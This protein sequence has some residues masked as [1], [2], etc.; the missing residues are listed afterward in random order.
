MIAL[1]LSLFLLLIQ[2]SVV[3]PLGT[4]GCDT[5]GVGVAYIRLD[6][7]GSI[8]EGPVIAHERKHLEQI[9]RFA[10][11]GEWQRWYSE[12]TVEAEA[13]AFCAAAKAA[14]KPDFTLGGAVGK[15]AHSMAAAFG[16]SFGQALLLIDAHC[17]GEQRS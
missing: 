10:S 17:V 2:Q 9:K 1:L 8:E 13:E 11:C 3:A 14:V 15:Y 5:H 4:T 16:I 12:N 7:L 6:V